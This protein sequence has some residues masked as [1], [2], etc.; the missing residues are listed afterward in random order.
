MFYVNS[1]DNNFE[2]LYYKT[3]IKEI[4]DFLTSDKSI[5]EELKQKYKARITLCEKLR[6]IGCQKL[7]FKVINLSCKD[8]NE[9]NDMY[10]IEDLTVEEAKSKK[11][12]VITLII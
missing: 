8:L 5:N 10:K 7:E 4:G 3:L 9:E 2:K 12:K 6:K 1:N 11:L